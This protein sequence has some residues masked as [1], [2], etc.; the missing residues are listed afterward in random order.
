MSFLKLQEL[1]RRWDRKTWS[2]IRRHLTCRG[3]RIRPL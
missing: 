3:Q 2:F 1:I